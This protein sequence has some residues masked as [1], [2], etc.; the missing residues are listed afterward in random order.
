ML[1]H[2]KDKI[3]DEEKPEVVYKIPCK[4]CERVYVTLEKQEDHWE[5]ERKNIVKKRIALQESLLEQKRPAQLVSATNLQL[6]IMFATRILG[7]RQGDWSRIRQSWQTCKGG[8]MDQEDREHESR[9]WELPTEPR[10]GQGFTYG[11]VGRQYVKW[12]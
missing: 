9:P 8:D 2:P 5:Q 11:T 6:Q 10:M 7:E 12:E 1:V 4:N 3:S